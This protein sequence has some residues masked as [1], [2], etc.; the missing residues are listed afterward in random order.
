MIDW[1]SI[2]RHSSQRFS[3]YVNSVPNK[4]RQKR[5]KR[6]RE[7]Q[8]QHLQ[9]L[10]QHH[11]QVGNCICDSL[12]N[13]VVVNEEDEHGGGGGVGGGGVGVGGGGNNGAVAS[14]SF[15]GHSTT[16]PALIHINP[17]CLI[18]GRNKTYGDEN[19]GMG[20]QQP[21]VDSADSLMTTGIQQRSPF[22][23]HNVM[24]MNSP[25][26]HYNGKDIPKSPK[27]LSGSDSWRSGDIDSTGVGIGSYSPVGY[28]MSEAKHANGDD[29]WVYEEII[30]ERG[31]SGLGFSIAG[32]TD[33]PHVDDDPSIYIT[34]LIPGG[35]AA[36][37]GRLRIGDVIVR[38]NSTSV[39][40]V[41]HATAVDALKRA[42]N[43]VRLQVRR[44]AQPLGPMLHEIELLKGNKGLGFSIAGGIGNQHI[45]GDNGI[46]I[47]KISEGGAAYADGRLAVGDKLVAVRNT[48]TGEKN[49]ENV[50]H[51]EAVATLKATENRVILLVA[52]PD[53]SSMNMMNQMMLESRTPPPSAH[54]QNQQ[55][56][57]KRMA[58][59]PPPKPV[60]PTMNLSMNIKPA[61]SEERMGGGSGSTTL[62]QSRT[63]VASGNTPRGFSD[64]D[65]DRE[66]RTVTL[67]KGS[68]GLGFNI[69]G[70][71]DSEG[72]FIS[73]ILA[74]GPADQSGQLK[75]GDQ[76]VSV[77]GVDL[78][79]AT[80]EEAAHALKNAGST[81]TLVVQHKAE[82]YNRFEAK[83]H[84]MKQHVM[85]GSLMRTSQKRT[86]YVRALNDFDPTK[87]DNLP[88]RGLAFQFGD[89]LHVTNA[90]DDEWWQAKRVLSSG[91]EEGMGIIPSKKRWER[92]QKARDRSVK[93]Q[94]KSPTQENKVFEQM[95]T[96]ERKKKN[97]SFTRKFPFMKSRDNI[98]DVSE[99]EQGIPGLDGDSTSIPGEDAV[100]SYEGVQQVSINYARPVIILGPMKDR[101]NDDLISE[102]PDKFGSCVPHTTRPRR[103]YEVN[104]RDYH[105]V[106]SREQMER[107]IQNHLFI[108]AGQYNDNLYGTSLAA[109]KEV[110]DKGKHCILDV[111]GN[112]IK[113]LHA[114]LLYPIAVFI[115][116]KSA[117]SIMEMNKRTTEE[118][119]RKTFER[120]Q[121]TEQE[122]GEY[123]TAIVQGE[124]PEEIYEKVK[125][126]IAEQAGP[127]IW[128]PS[129]EKI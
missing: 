31:S 72:I 29:D 84:D 120:A 38:V 40:D 71:E 9:L 19:L 101:I 7:E 105:F 119:A 66:P 102:F 61:T 60:T 65:L 106:G 15:A 17:N 110:A 92:K 36:T 67:H 18:H 11:D 22:N 93:F 99:G 73:F 76:I 46:Y 43:T 39:V 82:E 127:N 30:L 51:E 116:P 64:D 83:I 81:V 48:P 49:L 78:T 129:K 35:A 94:G 103:E 32:G 44:K 20:K 1:V 91:Q 47:T 50:T 45:P 69:V 54:P 8:E 5:R 63:S 77:N 111:S 33:N 118:Q 95:S 6:Q 126:V 26:Q 3:S 112:A 52:K 10:K 58:T 62:S 87:D 16:S 28:P 27:V 86:L 123:F 68:S 89:I 109:V 75:R 100:L 108:E 55:M 25:S 88:S 56:E 125:R 80:H 128:V 117:E 53:P 96:L 21:L 57:S 115:R 70:G 4:V 122:F 42:G 12:S 34:K 97:F 114:A 90:C 23:H 79:S 107:D 37:D 98:D 59:P 85:T 104:G 2:V 124:T 24:T 41:P 14:G 13:L 121:K 113:R 74:G